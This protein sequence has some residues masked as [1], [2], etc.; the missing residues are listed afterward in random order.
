[1]PLLQLPALV[2]LARYTSHELTDALSQ[3]SH[4]ALSSNVEVNFVVAQSCLIHR[5]PKAHK[6]LDHL[7]REDK[8]YPNAQQQCENG[9]SAKHSFGAIEELMRIFMIVLHSLPVSRFEPRC[10]LQDILA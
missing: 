2:L 9:N 5:L 8:A 6:R 1:M 4:F 7:A 10:H 3:L